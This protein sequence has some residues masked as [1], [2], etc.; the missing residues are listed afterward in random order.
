MN[1]PRKAGRVEHWLALLKQLPLINAAHTSN[2]HGE[3]MMCLLLLSRSHE[4]IICR[5]VV[6]KFS[7]P[8]PVRVAALPCNLHIN[9]LY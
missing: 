4:N 8:H 2:R 6:N 1:E 7:L 3:D 9:L 5:Y